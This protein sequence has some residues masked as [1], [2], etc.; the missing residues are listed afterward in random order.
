MEKRNVTLRTND[1]RTWS[2]NYSLPQQDK[3]GS[4]FIRGWK[5]FAIDNDLQAGEVCK[6]EMTKGAEN[7]LKVVI[8]RDSDGEAS[9]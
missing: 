3:H 7:A 9:L 4:F 6:F 2:V 8:F 1:G 5:Q